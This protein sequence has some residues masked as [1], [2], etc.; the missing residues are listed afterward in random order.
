MNSNPIVRPE[1]PT[2]PFTDPDLRVFYGVTKREFFA[3]QILASIAGAGWTYTD[4]ALAEKA[5][6]QADAL[7]NALNK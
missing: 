1:D 7:I 5:V 6:E 3:A 4:R 2:F